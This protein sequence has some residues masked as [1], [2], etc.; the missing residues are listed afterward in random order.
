[1]SLLEPFEG[2]LDIYN[3]EDDELSP[4]FGQTYNFKE[5]D[6]LVYNQ[7]LSPYWD[8]MGSTTL[9]CKILYVDYKESYCI[10]ELV[11]EWNDA[12]ENDIMYLKREVIDVLLTQHVNKY[13]LITENVLNFHGSDDSY[14]QE[15]LDDIES[16]SGFIVVLNAL[17]HV[18]REMGIEGL[19]RFLFFFDYDKWRTHQPQHFFNYLEEKVFSKL[20]N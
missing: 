8:M 5:P 10:I 12:V 3:S 1:M 18:K 2:W 14:Y 11:G 16:E 9:Y 7:I 13:V 19:S 6:N 4:F 15:W 17:E 20:L